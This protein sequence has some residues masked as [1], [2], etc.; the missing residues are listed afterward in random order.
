LQI[1]K[2]GFNAK[3]RSMNDFPIPEDPPV[4]M[5]VVKSFSASFN[6]AMGWV[7]DFEL[8]DSRPSGRLR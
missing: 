1:T 3:H 2:A 7:V 8:F 5:T 4:T 6:G